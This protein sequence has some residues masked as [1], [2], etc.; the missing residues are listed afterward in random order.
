MGHIELQP[1]NQ[2]QL[3]LAA[4]GDLG[5]VAGNP[6]FLVSTD[7]DGIRL[8]SADAFYVQC[9]PTLSL[10]DVPGQSTTPGVP[11]LVCL[12]GPR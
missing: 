4:G 1:A 11:C 8:G 10:T 3:R 7:L 9:W 5:Q 6:R 12:F 2:H